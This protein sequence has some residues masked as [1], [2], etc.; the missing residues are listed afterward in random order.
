MKPA[1]CSSF[2]ARIMVTIPSNITNQG[3]LSPHQP[4]GILKNKPDATKPKVAGLK[5]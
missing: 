5:M 3:I 2:F 4:K 1:V